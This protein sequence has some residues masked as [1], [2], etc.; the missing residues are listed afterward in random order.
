MALTYHVN[1]LQANA[2]QDGLK[3][4][5]ELYE[6]AYGLAVQVNGDRRSHK[7]IMTSLNNLGL[8][9]YEMGEFAAADVCLRDLTTYINYVKHDISYGVETSHAGELYECMLNA[10]ILRNEH[11]CAGAA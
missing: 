4:A 6:M 9:K 3:N 5:M 1:S 8:I 7:I 2:M 11:H 10:M